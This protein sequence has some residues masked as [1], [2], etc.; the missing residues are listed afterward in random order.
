VD[1][2]V[3]NVRQ[4]TEY[5]LRAG[6][7]A[8]DA[9][10]LQINGLGGPYAYTT[11]AG[12]YEGLQA[13]GT[14]IG[15]GVTLP[16][17]AVNTG[18]IATNLLTPLGCNQGWN[19]Y[20]SSAGPAYLS[21]G[22]AGRFCFDGTTLTFATAAPGAPGAGIAS[23]ATQFAIAA[24]LGSI[25][26]TWVLGRDPSAPMEAVTKE[27]ADALHTDSVW[28]FNGRQGVVT[29]LL[30]DITG[31]GGAPIDSP[32]FTGSPTA[33]TPAAGDAS[34]A[35]AT[36]A[37]VADAIAAAIAALPE[38]VD[39]FNGRTGDV[40][41]L[42]SD[43]L[44]A[45]GAPILSPAFEGD[46]TAPTPDPSSNSDRLATTLWVRDRIATAIEDA[47]RG[48]FDEIEGVVL[49]WNGRRGHVTLRLDDITDVGGAPIH[50]PHFTGVPTA[51]T[52][53]WTSDDGTVAT[54]AF[55]KHWCASNIAG[56]ASFNGRMGHVTLT[57]QDILEAGGAPLNSPQFTGTPTVPNPPE[58]DVSHR[59]ATTEWV[60]E[61]FQRATLEGVVHTFNGRSGFVTLEL[62][63]IIAA[64]GAPLFSPELEGRPSTPTPPE[65]SD[66]FS[67]ANTHW[68]NIE[69]DR[70]SD[71]LEQQIQSSVLSFNGRHGHVTLELNDVIAAHG[72]PLDSPHLTGR[73]EAPTPPAGDASNRIATTE[74]VRSAIEKSLPQVGPPGPPGPRGPQGDSFRFKSPVARWQDLPKHGNE[75]GD[76][77]IAEDSGIGY[78]WVC[79]GQPE[80]HW[81]AVGYLR[82]P[83]GPA[84][85]RGERGE[86]GKPGPPLHA[87]GRV[88]SYRDLPEGDCSEIGDLWMTDEDPA[89]HAFVW[90]GF[91]WV[92]MGDWR[93]PQGERGPQGP[94]GERGEGLRVVGTVQDPSELP[95]HGNEPGDIWVDTTTSHAW[96]WEGNRWVDIGPIAGIQGPVGPQGPIGPQ[97]PQGEQGP[98]GEDGRDGVDGLDGEGHRILGV[99]P[100]A[101]ALPQLDNR[102]GD[103]WIADDTGHGWRW[104]G[105]DWVDIG[106]LRGPPGEQGPPGEGHRILGTLD[107]YEQLPWEG[108]T[109][110]DIWIIDGDGF[111]WN[112][113][114]WINIG[115]LRGPEGP[116]PELSPTPP[117]NPRTGLLWWNESDSQLYIWTGSEWIAASCCEAASGLAAVS[118]F[119]PSEPADGQ[120]WWNTQD[121]QL[122]IWNGHDW[123]LASRLESAD[124]PAGT[125]LGNPGPGPGPAVPL[126]PAEI[127]ELIRGQFR[128]T[129]QKFNANGTYYRREGLRYAIVEC[130][131]AGGGGG[132][133]AG[134]SSA[135][136]GGG[137]GSG[138]YSRSVLTASEIG[139]SQPVTIGAGGPGGTGTG[140]STNGG[141][142]SFGSLVIANGGLIGMAD[143]TTT[144]YRGSGGPGAPAGTGQLALPGNAGGM[145]IAASPRAYAGFG[146]NIFGGAINHAVSIISSGSVA[147]T[148][149]AANTGAG[150]TGS[151]NNSSTNVNGGN[152]GSGWC[153]VTEFSFGED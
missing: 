66:D 127:A 80:C 64:G 111:R 51:P 6:A 7:G 44:A 53:P 8:S 97:G 65:R 55:V 83:V 73:P 17:D 139:A 16:P 14:E 5:P 70:L 39:S 26:Q 74:F 77:R 152:G 143:N 102:V 3:V 71:S 86:E 106:P 61:Y 146:G 19:W 24:G 94:Q 4:I 76:V 72:A 59:I 124:I 147:G 18:V 99:V 75:P 150:G 92:D 105:D 117:D 115:P 133:T 116:L 67:I 82:G 47:L 50:D 58:W 29:L 113:E 23:W 12:L 145:G 108:N 43:I 60:S 89:G 137:G 140:S 79:A 78:V 110:G 88:P 9:V 46:P 13:I 91:R 122:Y 95:D 125:V 42:L 128:I 32:A 93:G 144:T 148:N 149:G 68:V 57:L 138:G 1:D 136:A 109:V 2:W 90:D 130:V 41:L 112:G 36:T 38:G 69:L 37:F 103:I 87:K 131:G 34:S 85:P 35:I 20:Q 135:N 153:L 81:S 118:E 101:D 11:V 141:A 30:G 129:T 151:A 49:T 54:T 100:N 40:V 27:Y 48:V 10:L 123:V 28:S 45:G 132:W 25:A 121:R 33:P 22:G 134:N 63:D 119:P 104:N 114:D 52:P 84:G 120:L 96:A 142:T 31:A 21:S 98:P 62:G 126:G 56:V 15:V 107:S